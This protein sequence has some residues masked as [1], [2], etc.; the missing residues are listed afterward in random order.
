M[1]SSC[2]GLDQRDY[3]FRNAAQRR[4]VA[5]MMAL[6]PAALSFRFF[7]A[8]AAD[9]AAPACFL[10]SAHLFRCA[11]A[12]LARAVADILRLFV[13]ACPAPSAAAEPCVFR[14]SAIWASMRVF[15]SS[16]PAMAAATISV[17]SFVGMPVNGI[18]FLS[19]K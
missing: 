4:F 9:E 10:A 11:A 16:K 2:F 8:G 13:G 15:C 6:R 17:L 18:G 3:P 14:S 1:E 19:K 5:S 12:I 7:R